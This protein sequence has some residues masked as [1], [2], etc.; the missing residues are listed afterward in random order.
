[1]APHVYI[2]Q[3][4]VT[5]LVFP[6]YQ[7]SDIEEKRETKKIDDKEKIYH[8]VYTRKSSHYTPV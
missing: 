4:K 2:W 7:P 3:K 5:G 6:E 1:M 8:A